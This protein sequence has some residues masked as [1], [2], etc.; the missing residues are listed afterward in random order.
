MWLT[1][2]FMKRVKMGRVQ[3]WSHIG[4]PSGDVE[5]KKEEAFTNVSTLKQAATQLL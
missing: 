1:A 3:E 5:G 2:D 4:E